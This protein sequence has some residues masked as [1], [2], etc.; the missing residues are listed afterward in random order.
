MVQNKHTN[1]TLYIIKIIQGLLSLL[2]LF[3]FS[4]SISAQSDSLTNHSSFNGKY[5]ASYWHDTKS[6][7]SQP[8]HWKGKQWATFA[9]IAGVGVLTYAFDQEIYDIVQK[10]KSRS[11]EN[12]S[13]YFIEPWGSGVYSLPLLAGLYISG[14]KDSRHRQVALTGLK[15][16]LL[17]GGATYFF[18]YTFHRH[19]PSDDFPPD[20]RR[21]E[22]PFP[23]TTNF[24]AFPSGHTSVAFAV[25]SV[26][27]YGYKDK[28]W[29]GITSY[30]IASLVGMSRI[31]DNK[32]WAS[33]IVGGATLGTFIGISLCKINLKN[34]DV[35]PAAFYGGYGMR[36]G[37][38][39]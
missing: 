27:A 33:D 13:K 35:G 12:I 7:V 38:S 8:A 1:N 19:R 34:V 4:I 14:D 3:G 15:A 5:L 6:I 37:Y 24:T 25:A 22:G 30:T 17:T 16:F 11:S 39:F 36:I 9:G 21:F 29:I 28:P 20:P 31:H 26:L 10:N 23:L 18:K 32:H 2:I